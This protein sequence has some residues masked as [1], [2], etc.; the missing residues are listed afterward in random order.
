MTVASIIM[1]KTSTRKSVSYV[2]L[3]RN[4]LHHNPRPSHSDRSYRHKNCQE[5]WFEETYIRH[6]THGRKRFTGACIDIL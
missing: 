2:G 5:D 6:Q 1:K 4:K 3:S